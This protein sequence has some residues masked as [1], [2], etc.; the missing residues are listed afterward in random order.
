MEINL[1]LLLKHPIK[2]TI[3][4]YINLFRAERHSKKY[5]GGIRGIFPTPDYKVVFEDK[6]NNPLNKDKWRY[7]MPWGDF[8]P[9]ALHQYYDNDGTLS[10]VAHE[11]L[12][13]ELRNIPKTFKKSDLPDWRRTPD[14]PEEFTIP[15]GV[16]FVST[17]DTWQYGWFEAWIKLPKGQSYW[18]AFW[19]SGLNT[20]PPEI[21]IFEGYS[22]LGPRYEG[23]T[24]FNR[25]F[26]KPNR[27][28]RP[29]LHYGSTEDGTKDDY[30]SYDVPV[31]ECTE[32]YVQYVCQWEK[33]FI[34]IYYDGVLVMETT[35]PEV[36]KW[37]NKSNA[38]QYVILNHGLHEDYPNNPDESAMIV[39]SFKVLQKTE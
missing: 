36:L 34:R 37:Y 33:D 26:K 3:K 6:F 17:K 39:K 8:H 4:N 24:F 19:L 28:I 14:M 5:N 11:G 29:N 15:T 23:Y 30:K 21:D 18:P 25:L 9:G 38:Q 12:V 1:S 32:R 10:Y 27:K 31:A 22:H 13:L 20:W 16:G 35:D 7:A 2:E